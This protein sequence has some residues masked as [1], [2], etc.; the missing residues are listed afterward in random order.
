MLYS[1]EMQLLEKFHAN[2]RREESF[3]HIF[4]VLQFL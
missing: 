1:I 4:L 2:E 3:N